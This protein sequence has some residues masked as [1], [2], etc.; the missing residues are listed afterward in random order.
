[1][2]AFLGRD[3]IRDAY[4]RAQAHDLTPVERRRWQLVL[5]HADARPKIGGSGR[6]R[7]AAEVAAAAPLL[8]LFTGHHRDPEGGPP[9]L[10]PE[11]VERL[12]V[13]FA[14]RSL[15]LRQVS[16][17]AGGFSRL[18]LDAR[19]DDADGGSGHGV[20]RVEQGGLFATDGAREVA[21]MR[22]VAA[23]GYPVPE[24]LWQEPDPGALGQPFFVMSFVAGAART[25]ADGVDDVVRSL[26]ALH[27]L[28]AAD[29]L[30]ALD[31]LAGRPPEAL[32]AGQLDRWH[33]VYREALADELPVLEEC[34]EWLQ[35]RLHPTGPSV[36]VH[37][38][39]G[40]GNVLQD[41][42]GVTAV[43]D[44]EFAHA[45]DPA[46]DWAYL[47]LIRG[48]RIAGPDEWKQRLRR[49]VDIGYDEAT[50]RAWETYN[51][52]KGACVNLTALEVFRTSPN[53][54]PDL[55]AIGTAVHLRFLARAVELVDRP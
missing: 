39:P 9:P 55:L 4:E 37:G 26:A 51:Q 53:P 22:A 47:A 23:H 33:A 50:W 42:R 17:I 27:A 20:V 28:D 38:D 18:M 16:V 52:V 32:L 35:A 15:T 13:W 44:W 34:F 54:T 31:G 10:D 5:E 19:W 45:G 29:E 2:T 30:A 6:D 48:R 41:A 49:V 25:D 14:T 21:V 43:I 7:L 11:L 24:V 1:M 36:A 40:P 8:E 46:E 3:E 12:R